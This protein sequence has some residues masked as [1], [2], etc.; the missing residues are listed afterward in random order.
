MDSNNNINNTFQTQMG[1]IMESNN[2]YKDENE[3]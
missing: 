2:E 1:S 3:F